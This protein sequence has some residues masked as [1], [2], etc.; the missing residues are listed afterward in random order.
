MTPLSAVIITYNEELNIA[1][2]IESLQ[3]VADE[4]IVV[5]SYSTDKTEEICRSF[6]VH[7]VQNPFKDYATQ[8]NFGNNLA[9]NQFILSLDADEALSE[10]LV[11]SILNWKEKGGLQTMQM[12]RLTKYCGQ[13]IKHCGW[14]PDSKFRLFDKTKARWAGEKVHEYLEIDPDATR[15][16]LNG[17]LHHYSFYTIG[18]HLDTINKYSSLKA[19]IMLENDK[20]VNFLKVL[21]RPL[22]RFLRDYFL[23]Q[24]FRDGFYGFVICSNSAY[25]V[26]LKYVKLWN[27]RH[28][29]RSK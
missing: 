18:Q 23:K 5:D 19:E 12:N 17:D 27:L 8:K 9:E 28:Y 4:I 22:V 14:Y 15:G 16:H 21:F 29:S 3:G 13:W 7:F 26:F 10:R 20:N 6:G 2:C 11:E 25:S 1:R 24:G